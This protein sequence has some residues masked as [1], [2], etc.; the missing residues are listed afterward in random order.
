MNELSQVNWLTLVE[1]FVCI[2]ADFKLFPVFEWEPMEF[3]Q[4]R[5]NR[6]F[7]GTERVTP[8]QSEFGLTAISLPQN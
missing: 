5:G 6:E 1:N 7:R 4:L 2:E 8:L 3:F